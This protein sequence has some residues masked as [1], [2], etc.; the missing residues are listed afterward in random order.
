MSTNENLYSALEQ[1]TL[2][3]ARRQKINRLS[4]ALRINLRIP[5]G[6]HL[7][8]ALGDGTETSNREAL[9]TWVDRAIPWDT[10][11]AI[12]QQDYNELAEQLARRL[13]IYE[14]DEMG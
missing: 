14:A 1:D 2:A 3:K 8:F 11:M 10:D 12:E 7:V 13:S 6:C 9:R 4:E 5:D